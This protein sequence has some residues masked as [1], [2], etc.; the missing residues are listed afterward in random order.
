MG[1]IYVTY[2]M[3]HSWE[4]FTSL[5]SDVISLRVAYY[6]VQYTWECMIMYFS[7]KKVKP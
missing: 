6:S 5:L 4:G 3:S 1:L 2:P 7:L